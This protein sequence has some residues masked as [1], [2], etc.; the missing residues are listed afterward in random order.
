MHNLEE[1]PFEIRPLTKDEGT[2]YLI[3][4][5]DFNECCSDGE[6]PQEAIENGMDALRGVILTLE[7]F[8]FPVPAPGSGGHSGKFMAQVPKSL[9]DELVVRARLDG[10]SFNA[11]VTTLLA[12]G[13]GKVHGRD[14]A[15]VRSS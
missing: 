8:G 13:I 9:Y 15:A 10:I 5:T 14:S 11:L 6:T 2:G 4:F 12:D 7:E 1:Y 3:T